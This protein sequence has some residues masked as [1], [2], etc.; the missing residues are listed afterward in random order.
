[1]CHLDATHNQISN[2][3][4][5]TST[6]EERT[7]PGNPSRQVRHKPR[8]FLGG[9]LARPKVLSTSIRHCR[10]QLG[11][12]HGNRSTYHCDDDDSIDKLHRATRVDAS[13]QSSGD[14]EP[15][16][17]QRETDAKD[18]EDGEVLSQLLCIVTWNCIPSLATMLVTQQI[19]LFHAGCLTIER[20]T[21]ADLRILINL[22]IFFGHFVRH[23]IDVVQRVSYQD[24][25]S[26]RRG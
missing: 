8:I 19:G 23:D 6:G 15:R 17:G 16:I 18:G 24:G 13:D 3:E 12:R 26:N 4:C 21:V 10:G 22:V 1:M 9:Q 20:L 5:D 11:Q 25:W 14:A 7:S 2:T